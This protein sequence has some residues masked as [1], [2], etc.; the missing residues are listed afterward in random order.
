MKTFS[1]I[2]RAAAGVLAILVAIALTVAMILAVMFGLKAVIPFTGF[3]AVLALLVGSWVAIGYLNKHEVVDTVMEYVAV[4]IYHAF[5][6]S[7]EFRDAEDVKHVKPR[8]DT[9]PD[10]Q[11]A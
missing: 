11:P 7:W 10:P 8:T 4:L 1:P 3:A 9:V 6:E 5:G 2:R